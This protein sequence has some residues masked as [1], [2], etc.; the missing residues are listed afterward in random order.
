MYLK[1]YLKEHKIR[2]FK[3]KYAHSDLIKY[4]YAI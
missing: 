1:V 2:G 3:Y 4:K